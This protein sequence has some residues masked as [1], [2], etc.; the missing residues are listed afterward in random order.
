VAGRAVMVPA[1]M[2]ELHEAHA[3]LTPALRRLLCRRP[4]P[5]QESRVSHE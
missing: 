4:R 1:A 2:I 3:A 5:D